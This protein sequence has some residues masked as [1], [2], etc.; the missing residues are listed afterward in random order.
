[1]ISLH[2]KHITDYDLPLDAHISEAVSHAP[3][4][5]TEERSVPVPEEDIQG[6]SMCEI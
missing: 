6:I 4:V 5:I 2:G 1:M 3:H